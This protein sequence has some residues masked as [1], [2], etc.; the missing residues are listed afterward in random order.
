[1]SS[2]ASIACFIGGR[3]VPLSAGFEKCDPATGQP[4][5]L[6]A[7]A[8]DA[9]VDR[10]VSAARG[11]LQGPWGRTRLGERLAFLERLAGHME[12]NLAILVAAEIADT[13]KP[14]T[15][16]TQVEIPRAIANFRA[17]A[18][19]ARADAQAA[20]GTTFETPMAGGAW[21]RNTVSRRPVGVIGIVAPWN[22]P[23]LLLTW[24]VAPALACGNAVVVKPSEHSPRTALL[25]ARMASAC[26]LPDGV[27]NVVHGHGAGAAGEALVSHPG[28]DAIT[29]TGETRTG[30]AIMR[31][32]SSGPRPVSLELGG[33]NPALIFADCD[34]EVAIAGTAR[35]VFDNCGQ[36]CLTTE[37]LFVQ[38]P[39]FERFA[40]GL[41]QAAEGLTAGDPWAAE[42]RLGP[43]ISAQ[44]RDKVL[45]LYASAKTAGAQLLTGG[46]A[47]AV[48]APFAEGYWV[49]PTLWTGLPDDAEI[50]RREVFGPCAHISVFDDEDEVV[51]RANASEFGLAA[52]V[53]TGDADRAERVGGALE[54][55]TVWV[56]CWRVRDERAPFGGFKKSGV[57]REGGRH[58]LDFYSEIKT[59]CA[60]QPA[61]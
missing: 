38:R 37:R 60:F 40:A 30:E 18:Q 15:P 14:V 43:A 33:K 20:S 45:G 21:A 52:T 17:F 11:A 27:L 2:L 42:T 46:G 54:S 19:I 26:G 36:V 39:V 16:T 9:L 12:A 8:D 6:V 32:A 10:A 50:C 28:V 5:A 31:A 51:T 57:G 29:F 56:N 55:G 3:E 48:P 34:L 58:S 49:A 53:W 13:G 25:L 23:L 35:S 22:L 41:V 44:Q 47:L 7:E 61:S 24:K 4:S 1:M 59:L